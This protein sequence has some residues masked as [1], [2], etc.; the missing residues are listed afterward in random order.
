MREVW[1][2]YLLCNCYYAG[3]YTWWACKY[4]SVIQYGEDYLLRNSCVMPKGYCYGSEQLC[5]DEDIR[6]YD[7][8][9]DYYA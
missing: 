3:S 2:G 6:I 9:D 1:Y 5:Y 7:R 8:V 4:G